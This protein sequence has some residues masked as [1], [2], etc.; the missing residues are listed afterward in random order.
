MAGY[1]M[2]SKAVPWPMGP[3]RGTPIPGKRYA[4]V[5]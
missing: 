4:T 2:D 5:G 3:E 1:P